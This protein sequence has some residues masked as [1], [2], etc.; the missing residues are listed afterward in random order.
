MSFALKAQDKNIIVYGYGGIGEEDTIEASVLKQQFV[1]SPSF[2]LSN[3][4]K[5]DTTPFD[6]PNILL[7]NNDTINIPDSL[8]LQS[9]SV[10]YNKYDTLRVIIMSKLSY[11]GI[12][13]Y[14]HIWIIKN[15]RLITL[16]NLYPNDCVF[17]GDFDFNN[18]ID[19]AVFDGR[20]KIRMFNIR[21][22]KIKKSRFRITLTGDITV[23]AKIV[24]FRKSKW[25]YLRKAYGN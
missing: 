7:L 21:K 14:C 10:Y 19:M 2:L 18:T 1:F 9:C 6:N 15:N 5:L 3:N 24:N 17:F 12:T 16:P 20:W 13:Q 4:V 23:R 22:L 25:K 11:Y 8:Y